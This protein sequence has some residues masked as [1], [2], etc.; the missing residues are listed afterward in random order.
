ML[1]KTVLRHTIGAKRFLILAPAL[2]L[3][4]IGYT[5]SYYSHFSYLAPF[6]R[7]LALQVVYIIVMVIVILMA[8]WKW[9]NSRK[10][11]R[12]KALQML[13]DLEE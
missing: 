9:K 1:Q 5:I 12:D 2:V 7:I 11:L 8:M 3:M 6:E 4:D 10:P 13:K